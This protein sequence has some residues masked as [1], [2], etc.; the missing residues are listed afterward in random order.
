MQIWAYQPAAAV[1]RTFLPRGKIE[2]VTNDDL[3]SADLQKKSNYY[4][5]SLC[6]H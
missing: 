4:K 2:G 3:P 5:F 6:K 1:G